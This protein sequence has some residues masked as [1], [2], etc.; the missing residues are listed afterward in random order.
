MEEQYY[1]LGTKLP[2]CLNLVL[3]SG[4]FE[5][6]RRSQPHS[7]PFLDAAVGLPKGERPIVR[8]VLFDRVESSDTRRRLI[9]VFVLEDVFVDEAAGLY[10]GK[11][12]MYALTLKRDRDFDPPIPFE[13]GMPLWKSLK[14]TQGK[15]MLDFYA[16][17]RMLLS[18]PK[19]DFQRILSF[20]AME[21]PKEEGGAEEPSDDERVSGVPVWAEVQLRDY[22]AERLDLLEEGLQPFDQERFMEY[23]TGDGGR[24]DLLC[25]DGDGNVVVVELKKGRPDE[26]V[27]G[28]LCRYLGWAMGAIA[29]G[30]PVR[31]M[32]VANVISDRLRMAARPLNGVVLVSYE[33]KFDVKRVQ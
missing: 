29:D 2:G 32:I 6:L 21:S 18:I 15:K 23:P 5:Y 8:F 1:I 22:L 30:K 16:G 28:Q 31:G 3:Q 26:R 12:P 27:V 9:G 10:K 4:R 17:G 13:Q 19:D 20:N 7:S 33:M 25:R 11:E 24:I 14:T